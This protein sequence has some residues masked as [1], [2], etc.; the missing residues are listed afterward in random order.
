MSLDPPFTAEFADAGFLADIP[1]DVQDAIPD[2]AVASR[3]PSPQAATW[4][5]KLAVFPFWSNTQVLWYRKSFVE[6]AGIDMTKPVTWDQII[7][8]ASE[9]GGQIGV[10]ANKYEGYVVWINALIS[11]AGGAIV[12]NADKGADADITID[13]DAGKTAARIIE[14][15]ASVQGR[16]P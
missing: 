2:R 12:E 6:K 3:E 5:D 14:K 13:S 10:Q 9:N 7:D 16:S 1:A 11:G 15:L 4:E 8:A